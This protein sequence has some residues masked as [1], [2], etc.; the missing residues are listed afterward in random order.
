MTLIDS[1]I[2]EKYFGHGGEAG[3]VM[4]GRVNADNRRGKGNKSRLRA[5]SIVTAKCMM[6]RQSHHLDEVKWWADGGKL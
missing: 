2:L 6:L 1:M 5:N 3:V 4:R